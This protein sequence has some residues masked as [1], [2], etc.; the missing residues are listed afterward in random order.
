MH[1]LA[2]QDAYYQYSERHVQIR[3]ETHAF[4]TR[5]ALGRWEEHAPPHLL[6]ARWMEVP[7]QAHVL[8]LHC[9][10]GLVG[11][12]AAQMAAQGQVTLLDCHAVAVEA[13]RR[14]LSA[15]QVTHA[16]VALSDCAQAVHGQKFDAVLATL[17]KGRAAWEQTVID[18]ATALRTGG[19]LYL[20]GANKGGIKSA[21]KFV[22]QVFGSAQVVAYQKGCRVL[23]AT[24]GER[25]S[26]PAGGDDYYAWREIAAQVDGERLDYVSKPGLFAW[27][28]LDEGTRTLIEALR[29][30]P[31]RPT[32]RVLDVGCGSGILTLVAAR[33][34]R[35]GHVT[36]VDVDCRAAEATRRTL[37]LHGIANA[38]ALLS[39]C[40]EAVRGERF[41]KVITNP[42]FHQARATTYAVATQ[43]IRDAAHV[44]ERHGELYLVANSFLRYRPIL[45]EAFG[46]ADLLRE[47]N[48]FKV[49][50]AIKR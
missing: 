48:R 44:L 45:E 1:A 13:A 24:R 18:A 8:N 35:Q 2:E 26:I 14:T 17:P 21:A 25:A 6:L 32:D 29:E 49:W 30:R 39:D 3:G 47:T 40:A 50:H 38:Q 41:S 36:G 15:H 10:N 20:A 22:A 12:I 46:D 27:K 7:A 19:H 16:Q 23:R 31:L 33:Q 42:P 34:A 37:A 4:F 43:I 28:Q 11:A 9:G 5:P